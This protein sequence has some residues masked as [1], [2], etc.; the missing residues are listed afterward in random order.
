MNYFIQL[1]IN[2]L[3]LGSIYAPSPPSA[4]HGLQHS[5]A[6]QFAH[7]SVYMAGA[8]GYYIL[9][10]TCWAGPYISWLPSCSL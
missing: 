3:A 4:T 1:L 5:G 8:F 10:V 2:G 6:G 9:V 7:G